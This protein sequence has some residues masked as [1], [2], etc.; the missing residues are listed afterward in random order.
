MMDEFYDVFFEKQEEEYVKEFVFL[1]EYD[2]FSGDI[3]CICEGQEDKL[4]YLPKIKG[5]LRKN[6]NIYEVGGKDNVL[7]VFKHCEENEGYDLNRIM[8]IVDRD[9]DEPIENEKIYE[10]PVYSVENLYVTCDVLKDFVELTIE[11]NNPKTIEKIIRNYLDREKEF[12]NI[13]QKLNI[14]LYITKKLFENPNSEDFIGYEECYLPTI[15]DNEVNKSIKV[16]L[17]KVEKDRGFD[18]LLENYTFIKHE[19][20]EKMRTVKFSTR[21]SR[22]QYKGKYQIYFFLSY[23]KELIKDMNLGK[24]KASYRILADKNYGCD[25]EL[26]D[27]TLFNILSN[28]VQL[29]LCLETYIKKFSSATEENLKFVGNL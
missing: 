5:I 12:N 1:S 29:P 23:I 2:N 16:N 14:C 20:I 26:K 22:A 21:N 15:D 4:C 11:V 3:Y 7:E 24:A 28:Y 27:K 9:F 10:L 8:F 25:I 17:I 19:D 18:S 6:V 13:V